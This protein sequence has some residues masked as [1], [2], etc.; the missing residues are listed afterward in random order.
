MA[1]R[2]IATDTKPAACY[3]P[4]YSLPPREFYPQHHSLRYGYGA[5]VALCRVTTA[6]ASTCCA[7]ITDRTI[8]LTTSAPVRIMRA[9]VFFWTAQPIRP[10]RLA[11]I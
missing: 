10:S 2:P 11:P 3:A 8:Y 5:P 6:I 7:V 4:H 1:M 9:G